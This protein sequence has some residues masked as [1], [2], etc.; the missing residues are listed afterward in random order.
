MVSN[1]EKKTPVIRVK[2][3]RIISPPVADNSERVPP[4]VPD[5]SAVEATCV[6]CPDPSAAPAAQQ[7]KKKRKGRRPSRCPHWTREFTDQCVEKAKAIF[8][9]L[10]AEGGGFLPLKV[11]ISR[12]IPVWLAEHPDAGLTPDE[13]N[14]AAFC[15]TSRR[16]YLQRT[17]VP[18]ALRYDL[19][20]KPAGQVSEDEAKNA[21][22]RLA[23]RERRWQERQAARQ[24]VGEDTAAK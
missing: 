3:R 13:W 2:K 6:V 11:G 23:I 4:S 12:D 24:N 21:Q 18:G 22:R 10:R 8:P 15:I 20:G 19:G 14:C 17:S 9:H 7:K 5:V 16:V 1:Q